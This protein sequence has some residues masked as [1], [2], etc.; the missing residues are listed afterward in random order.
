MNM[1]IRYKRTITLDIINFINSLAEYVSLVI[2][3]L[4][5]N[6][7]VS[8]IETTVVI[9]IPSLFSSFFGSVSVKFQNLLG[10]KRC[11]IFSSNIEYI[12][13]IP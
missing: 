1:L 13:C 2:L 5:I 12:Y 6:K 3:A 11:L 8:I 10:S 7:K 9:A 4:Y